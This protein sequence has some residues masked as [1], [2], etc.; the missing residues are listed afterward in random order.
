MSS[1]VKSTPGGMLVVWV[2]IS[3]SAG[4][5]SGLAIMARLVIGQLPGAGSWTW[6]TIWISRAGGRQGAQVPD[7]VPG[8][9]RRLG[10]W[11]VVETMVQLFMGSKVSVMMA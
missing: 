1:T 6:A 8:G 5:P 11:W 3:V 4:S 7:I 9:R 2:K 10:R